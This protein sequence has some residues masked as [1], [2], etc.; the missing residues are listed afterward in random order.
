MDKA[1]G[2]EPEGCG[3]ESLPLQIISPRLEKATGNL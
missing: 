3:L 2:L 1:P